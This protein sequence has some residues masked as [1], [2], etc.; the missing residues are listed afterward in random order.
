M[1]I[2]LLRG[3]PLSPADTVQSELVVVIDSLL[4]RN[5]FPGRDAVGQTITIPNW[6]ARR[7]VAAR[8]VG[9]AGHVEQ[10]GLDGSVREKPQIYYP[11]YQLPD[12]AA[13]WFRGEVSLVVR[14][15]LD[16]SIIMPAIKNAVDQAGSDQP[17]YNIRTMQALVSESMAGRRFPMALLSA[18]ALL[19]LL[20]A[21]VGIYGVIS[22][23]MARRVREIGIRM[24]LGAERRDVLRMVLGQGL[25]MALAG[26]GIGVPGAWMLTR[27]LASFSHLLYGVRPA[28]PLTFVVVLL[29]L[30]STALLA[31]AIPARRAARL[32]P[33][34]ALRH[35]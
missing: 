17:V 35:E 20:L 10:Y 1:K 32:D 34:A 24:A 19:A 25:G 27:V 13:P 7:N 2:P 22:Y 18:F 14:S 21:S 23:S 15:G 9:I 26:V 11:F 4:A 3:R 30:L 16:A 28:D 31:C 8:I 6:G 12:E 5:Y 33:M 29:V